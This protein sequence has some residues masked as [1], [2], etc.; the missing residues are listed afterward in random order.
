L[1]VQWVVL[2]ALLL[3]ACRVDEPFIC[4]SDDQCRRAGMTG[5]CE[6][7]RNCSFPDLDCTSGRRY[8]ELAHYSSQCVVDDD[9]DMIADDGDNCVAIANP[10]QYDEDQDGLGDVCDP[11]PPFSDNSDR[12]DDGVGDLCDPKPSVYGDSIAY[13]E[14]FHAAL[15]NTWSVAGSALVENDGLTLQG[16]TSADLPVTSMGRATLLAGITMAQPA[17]NGVWLGLPFDAAVGGPFCAL[18][19]AMLQLWRKEG[20]LTLLGETAFTAKVDTTYVLGIQKLGMQQ[21]RC[22]A[23]ANAATVDVELIVSGVGDIASTKVGMGTDATTRFAWV[24]LIE[25][26]AN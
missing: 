9:H 19:P 21:Y 15:A 16:I 3:S 7:S 11:C 14:G 22:S 5:T 26:S 18:T 23:R 24:M 20:A 13:F 25:N 17:M 8:D 6:A 2:A 12:D 10:E 4:A 1:R